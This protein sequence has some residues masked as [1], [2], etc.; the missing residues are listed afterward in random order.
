MYRRLCSLLLC[1][2]LVPTS[3][4]RGDE[5]MPK[6]SFRVAGYLPDYRV[7]EFDLDRALG[8]TD[9]ILFSAE[10]TASGEISLDRLKSIDWA[11]FRQW[12]KS[13]RV[14]LILAIGGW[15]RSE[16]FATVSSSPEARTKFAKAVKRICVDQGLDGIDLD[17]EHP[18]DAAEAENY[19]LLL[20]AL[21]SQLRP[22]GLV[23]SLTM[24]GWQT[25][26]KQASDSVD[27]I[28]VMAYDQPG[29]HSTFDGAVADM[30][31][32]ETAGASKSKLVLGI[33]FYARHTSRP[34]DVLT[35]SEI[36]SKHGPQLTSDEV[37]GYYFNGVSTIRRK[38]QWSRESG[39]GG[40]MIWE[41]GQDSHK[42]HPLLKVI[43]SVAK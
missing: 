16:H 35:Y 4:G 27:W 41:L 37:N 21:S 10:P 29:K 31:R 7:A 8:L 34:E 40:V 39:Y 33:P 2:S 42:E 1:L 36:V 15:W 38:T 19:G 14:R 6:V 23:I 22:M 28:Q 17:W 18:R 32:L 11:K 20:S 12:K 25:L 30:K 5:P 24:A 9:L 13:N 26:P 43:L 3:H